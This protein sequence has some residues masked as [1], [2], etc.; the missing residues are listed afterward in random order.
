MNLY[1]P[2]DRNGKTFHVG[3]LVEIGEGAP[4]EFH[5]DKGRV[6]RV[7]RL[8]HLP[9]IPAYT[10]QQAMLSQ[11]PMMILDDEDGENSAVFANTLTILEQGDGEELVFEVTPQ[12]VPQDAD[13]RDIQVGDSVRIGGAR[14]KEEH[15]GVVRTVENPNPPM[16]RI[17]LINPELFMLIQLGIAPPEGH[18]ELEDGVVHIDSI[19]VVAT[20]ATADTVH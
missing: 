2:K 15:Q 5:G 14:V 17:A 18:I 7:I 13:G 20:A 6:N 3:D 10:G 9:R 4:E 12:P 1:T 16:E 11:H 8:E 19:E